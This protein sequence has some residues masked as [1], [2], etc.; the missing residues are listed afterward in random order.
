MVSI[1]FFPEVPELII[2]G[3]GDQGSAPVAQMTHES[4]F[5]RKEKYEINHRPGLSQVINLGKDL[6]NDRITL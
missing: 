6:K 2:R 1:I 4:H 5:K 3:S